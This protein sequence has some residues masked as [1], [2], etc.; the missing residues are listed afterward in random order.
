MLRDRNLNLGVKN[1]LK[2]EVLFPERPKGMSPHHIRAAKLS[3]TG[4][5]CYQLE[6]F[7]IDS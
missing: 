4:N 1:S 3:N 6:F 2:P 5:L 7:L